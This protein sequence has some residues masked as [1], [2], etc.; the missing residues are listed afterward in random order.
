MLEEF[1]SETGAAHT[2]TLD[3]LVSIL[4][5][6]RA[7]CDQLTHV[8]Q[9]LTSMA[10]GQSGAMVPVDPAESIGCAQRMLRNRLQNGT[11]GR[12]PRRD[13]PA[14]DGE[15]RTSAAGAPQPG[16]QR[17]RRHGDDRRR[18]PEHPRGR[19]RRRTGWPSSSRTAVPA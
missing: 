19:R 17:H 6:C 3:E 5:D 8:A 15:P 7:A 10:R 16:G 9:G 11:V 14:R 1:R 12:L 13:A 18:H 4:D 2:E